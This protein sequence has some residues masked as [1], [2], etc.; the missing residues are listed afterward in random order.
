[1]TLNLNLAFLKDQGKLKTKESERFIQVTN[2]TGIGVIRTINSTMKKILINPGDKA[3]SLNLS[4]I[5]WLY[6][7]KVQKCWLI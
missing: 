3:A 4:R 7:E 6:I 5:S 1:M 2:E